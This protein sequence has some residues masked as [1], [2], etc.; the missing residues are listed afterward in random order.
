MKI[1]PLLRSFLVGMLLLTLSMIAPQKTF[2]NSICE[3]SEN[4][5]NYHPQYNYVNYYG[6]ITTSRNLDNSYIEFYNS[7]D[8]LVDCE[9]PY[10]LPNGNYI[11]R[12]SRVY[13]AGILYYGSISP[14]PYDD[15]SVGENLKIRIDGQLVKLNPSNIY[16]GQS[17]N[18]RVDI[19]AD[20]IIEP[21]TEVELSNLLR[22]QPIHLNETMA[23]AAFV[24]NTSNVPATNVKVNFKLNSKY[25]MF[26]DFNTATK[27][28]CINR[29]AEFDMAYCTIPKLNPGQQVLIGVNA[30]SSNTGTYSVDA[31]IEQTND[32]NIANNSRSIDY[33][34]SKLTKFKNIS[35]TGNSVNIDYEL[36]IYNRNNTRPI[37]LI[38]IIDLQHRVNNRNKYIYAKSDGSRFGSVTFNNLLSGRYR[39]NIYFLQRQG[40]KFSDSKLFTITQQPVNQIVAKPIIRRFIPEKII[41]NRIIPRK[42][43]WRRK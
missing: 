30:V 29:Y 27:D 18:N 36:D 41:P 23:I 8:Q 15:L 12:L 42:L 20:T 22:T 37:A 24:K 5:S 9:K 38:K 17:F 26:T 43:I 11:M 32:Q 2:A 34:V 4:W 25:S 35:V 13:Q 19:D 1:N 14:M 39:V 6:D 10:K 7:K 33:S 16:W 28:I 40:N 31:N 3:G 21:K